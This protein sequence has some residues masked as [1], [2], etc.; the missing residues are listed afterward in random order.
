MASLAPNAGFPDPD[1]R[2]LFESAP[3]L[4]LVLR[5]D[6][7]IVAASD[8]YI[9]ATMT[10][11]DK[12]VGR[13]LFEAFPDDPDDPSATG[14]RNLHA[15]LQRVIKT[16]LPDVMAV[17]KYAIRRGDGDFEERHWSP[18]NTPVFG[19]DKALAYI[20]HRVEDVTEFIRLTQAGGEQQR[21]AAELLSRSEQIEAEIVQ[22][23]QQLQE[24][25]DRL[26]D[27]NEQLSTSQATVNQVQKLEAVG[28]LTGG[29]AHDFNNL[30]TVIIGNIDLL[31]ADVADR[32]AGRRMMATIRR[33]AER[34]ARLTRQLLAFSRQQTLKPETCN[35]NAVLIELDAAIKRSLGDAVMV[36]TK[37]NPALWPCNIDIAQFDTAILNVVAN[38]SDA[39]PQGGTLSLT[40]RNVAVEPADVAE[41]GDIR[42]GRYVAV[43][44]ADTGVGMSPDAL[45]RAFDPFFTTKGVGKGSGLG[46]SQLYG[47]VMQ[48]GGHVTLDSEPGRGTVVTIYL[49]HTTQVSEQS[50]GDAPEP[51]RIKGAETVLVVEDDADVLDVAVATLTDLGYRILLAY[52]GLEALQILERDEPI[53]LLFTDIVMPSGISGVQLAREAR[54]LRQDI[55]VLMTSGYTTQTLAQEYGANKEYQIITKPYRQSELAE[56]V[57]RALG[58][59][60]PGNG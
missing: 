9:E 15:S 28:Q 21:V 60:D 17:Q 35:L 38:A 32:E 43:A 53:D 39:M 49:P 58:R 24:A 41:L 46:L 33:S 23:A 31:E 37:L 36:R 51:P 22:R 50:Q 7:M 44:L 55:K 19:A 52:N 59:R 14:M 6:L 4:Y 40:T 26:R 25:N 13:N 11:R 54:R 48:S 57:R 47:F 12:I 8:S 34:G 42:P 18:V 16:G 10:R 2:L 45:A 3:G 20:I 27:A 56:Q 1:F 30:L 5:P 29:I